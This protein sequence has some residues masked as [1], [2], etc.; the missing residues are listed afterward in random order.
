MRCGAA[1][2]R[3]RIK[4]QLADT[5]GCGAGLEPEWRSRMRSGALAAELAQERPELLAKAR[6]A[7]H[8]P[9]ARVRGAA[10]G[11]AGSALA[12]DLRQL[13]V[14]P[15]PYVIQEAA[16]S[17]AKENA[18]ASLPTALSVANL[19]CVVAGVRYQVSQEEEYLL[20][21]YGQGFRV[22]AARVGRFVPGLGKMA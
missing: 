20:R 6:E 18:A 11:A 2:A 3:D 5:P 16:G 19:L 9:D 7:L 1:L 14:D 4:K 12:E 13:L 22:Y 10:A 17:L 15:D 8:D 21:T